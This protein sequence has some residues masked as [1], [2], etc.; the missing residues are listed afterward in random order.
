MSIASLSGYA[1]YHLQSLLF[2][3]RVSKVDGVRI[4]APHDVKDVV[5]T[6]D[7]AQGLGYLTIRYPSKYGIAPRSIQQ[8]NVGIIH[9]SVETNGWLSPLSAYFDIINQAKEGLADALYLYRDYHLIDLFVKMNEDNHY[10]IDEQV[11]YTQITFPI[12]GLDYYGSLVIQFK[13]YAVSLNEL[14]NRYN[15]NR[16]EMFTPGVNNVDAGVTYRYRDSLKSRF[17]QIKKEGINP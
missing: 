5:I 10:Q 2:Q 9:V 4:I 12:N 8:R 11:I 6:E 14:I 15:I 17:I 3:E 16:A 1:P 7:N 13:N